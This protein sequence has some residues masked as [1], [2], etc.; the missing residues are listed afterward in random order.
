MSKSQRIF[1]KLDMCIYIME[2]WFEVANWQI[3]SI[4]DRFRFLLQNNGVVLW[5]GIIV[6]FLFA[7]HF[8]LIFH[9]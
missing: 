2:I 7:V 8:I 6:L 4:S 3:L 1:A 5:R 9:N